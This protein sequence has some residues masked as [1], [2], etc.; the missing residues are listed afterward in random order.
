[1]KK[2]LLYS[3]LFAWIILSLLFAAPWAEATTVTATVQDPSTQVFANGT[4]AVI[5]RPTPGATGPFNVNGVAFTQSFSGVMNGSG[6]L[7]V[8]LTDNSTITPSGSLWTFKVCPNASFPCTSVDIRITG[9]NLDVSNIINA[10]VPL[11]QTAAGPLSYAYQDSEITPIPNPGQQYWNVL[12]NQNR[13]WNGSSW[14]PLISTGNATS[15]Q[16]LTWDDLP[17]ILETKSAT[18]PHAA[19]FSSVA[20]GT[21]VIAK[22]SGEAGAAINSAFATAS[23]VEVAAA[24]P[25][26]STLI[27]IPKGG[28]LRMRGNSTLA[29]V[30]I[31]FTDSTT[32]Y[33]GTGTLDC[34]DGATL[35]LANGA[36]T[37]SVSQVHFASLTGTTNQYGLSKVQING[38][39]IDGNKANN[40]SGFGV[41]V[42]GRGFQILGATVQNS[43]QTGW[44]LEGH[45]P[46]SFTNPADDDL[47]F[48]A[49]SRSISNG[50]DGM[51]FVTQQGWNLSGIGIWGS[52]S[53]GLETSTALSV[54]NL[55]TFL[56]VTGGC[57]IKSA[58]SMAGSNIACTNAAGWGLLID[59]GAGQSFLSSSQAG[60]NGCIG[61]E[62]KSPNQLFHGT[63][64]N[65]SP[66]V[67]ING[68]AINLTA[69]V[70]GNSG[71]NLVALTAEN[72]PSTFIINGD[73]SSIATSIFSATPSFADTSFVFASGGCGGNCS[74]Q[75]L[76][77]T[78]FS[79]GGYSFT[80]PS[81]S[82]TL[83]VQ[84][85][86]VSTGN[87]TLSGTTIANGYTHTW[88]PIVSY[89]G[90]ALGPQAFGMATLTSGTVTVSNAA[91]CTPSATCG[92]K[93]IN[94][95][96]NASSG[97]GALSIGT[98][99]AGV[100][101]V[102]NSLGP[103]ASV[104]TTDASSVCWQ[105]N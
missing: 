14:Q 67:K 69:N 76:P 54:S 29:H 15:L 70:F 72:G 25:T 11:I 18:S 9:S 34:P 33:T 53:W 92:Y 42:Y 44:W 95:A 2:F 90:A 39:T 31:R 10:A 66:A 73:T 104:L 23:V 102:I 89:V 52:G 48:M 94:C 20:T 65:S 99:S 19:T 82:G 63:I 27:T 40:T 50:G 103:T 59:T 24:N 88:Q 61:I 64:D 6:V 105:I 41:R 45:D 43:Y 78:F 22:I 93:L 100:S 80:F 32:D 79:A 57:H 28:T 51:N 56:N 91:A 87:H 96:K 58:G 13:V 101:F 75:Q 49:N 68:G 37:D 62:V 30:G 4:W 86:P 55:N 71:A 7:S 97:I 84:G 98:V 47:Q 83:Y 26:A 60:C 3:M 1:M 74:Y 5:F 77:T 36:N 38:C 85:N 17:A 12:L 46:A 16:G 81:A 35:K 21:T 8:T